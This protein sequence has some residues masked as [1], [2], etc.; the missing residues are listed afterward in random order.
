MSRRTGARICRRSCL[1]ARWGSTTLR[2]RGVGSARPRW[3]KR[4]P[5]AR[6]A[7][8]PLGLGIPAGWLDKRS[9]PWRT[10]PA[11]GVW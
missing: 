2:I 10:P 6:L 5:T 1:P 9:R 4:T 11:M 3:L 8:I 7:P